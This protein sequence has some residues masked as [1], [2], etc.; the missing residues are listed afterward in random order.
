MK[1]KNYVINEDLTVDVNEYVNISYKNLK[2]IPIRFGIINGGFNCNS[3]HLTSLKGCPQ[4]IS[5]TFYCVDN[6]L[7]NLE[8][9][10][11]II[12]DD[13]SCSDNNLTSFECF[14]KEING[15]FIYFHQ[16]NIDEKE[17]FNFNCKMKNVV[18]LCSDFHKD[19]NVEAFFNKLNYYKIIPSENELLKELINENVNNVKLNKK[20]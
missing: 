16:N 4:K 12:N 20:L 18:Y 9:C 10:P 14:S 15:I 7:I 2:E 5:G 8:Y 13:F 11:E 17:L 6:K 3:N 19:G 1:I